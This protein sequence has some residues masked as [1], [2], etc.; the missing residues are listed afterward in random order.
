[1]QQRL[2]MSNRLVDI[3]SYMRTL[4]G[5]AGTIIVRQVDVEVLSKVQGHTW[6][7]SPYRHR[8]SSYICD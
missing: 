5:N 7:R 3:G 6:P 2:S 4:T 8:L 1:M